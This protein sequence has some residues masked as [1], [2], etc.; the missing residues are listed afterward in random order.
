MLFTATKGSK[1]KA[2]SAND[3]DDGRTGLMAAIRKAG[4]SG[5]VTLKSSKERKLERKKGKE[6]PGA[7]GGGDLMGDLFSKL[8]MRRKGISG[9]KQESKQNDNM[10]PM[11]KISA[12]I[13]APKPQRSES[14]ESSDWE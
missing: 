6:V 12:M 3:D 4:G 13:P 9:T 11:D 2:T 7:S 5:K 1:V 14:R 10:S 8:T